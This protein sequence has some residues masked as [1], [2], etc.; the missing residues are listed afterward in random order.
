MPKFLSADC[1]DFLNRILNT[2]PTRRITISDI[3]S[4]NYMKNNGRKTDL[5][6]KDLGLYPGLQKM[7]WDKDFLFKLI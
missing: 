1:K 4:H 7:P 2:D 6:S 3:R 5:N